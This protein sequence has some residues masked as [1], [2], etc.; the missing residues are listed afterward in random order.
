MP[1]VAPAHAAKPAGP[2]ELLAAELPHAAATA[3][4]APPAQIGPLAGAVAPTPAEAPPSAAAPIEVAPP[5]PPTEAQ[6]PATASLRLDDYPLERCAVIAA[7]IARKKQ[8]RVATLEKHGLTDEKW[9][10]VER[11]WAEAIR[12]EG[13]R[14]K[15]ALMRIYDQEYV[16][17]LEAERGAI[18]A[19]EYAKVVVAAERGKEPEVLAEL[20]L[21]RGALLRLQR[22]WMQKTIGSATLGRRVRE[23]IEHARET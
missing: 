5:A 11:H 8:D 23:L 12:E 20:G 1:I 10:T 6:P 17:Q 4:V 22:V 13:T 15:T 19:E 9:Q 21:P 14:G 2:V 3:G 16:A 18:T 7:S